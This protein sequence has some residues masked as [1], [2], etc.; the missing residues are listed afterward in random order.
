[1]IV[2]LVGYTIKVTNH[3]SEV[4]LEERI[5]ALALSSS[6]AQEVIN[7]GEYT[8]TFTIL[9]KETVLQ[10]KE[11]YPDVYGILPDTQLYQ[12]DVKGS[13]TGYRIILDEK[14]IYKEIF[15]SVLTVGQE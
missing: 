11:E 1:M 8:T 9:S 12:V 14:E 7:N 2:F 6:S 5:T 3:D 4:P 15:I 10:M 13:T